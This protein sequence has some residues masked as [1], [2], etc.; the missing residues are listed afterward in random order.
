MKELTI[1]INEETISGLDMGEMVF[2]SGKVFTARDAAH[3]RLADQ[4]ERGEKLPFDFEGQVV[5]Y[6]GP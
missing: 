1:P 5:F 3:K 6:A 2:L 4:I